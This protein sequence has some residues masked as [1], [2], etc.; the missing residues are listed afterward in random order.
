M[1]LIN[2]HSPYATTSPIRSDASRWKSTRAVVSAVEGVQAQTR[3][4]MRALGRLRIPTLIFVNK[5]DRAGA[6]CE[7]LLRAIA[8][9]LTPA[10]IP[11]GSARGL[12]TRAADAAAY[13]A[14]DA[15]FTSGMVERLADHDEAIL[16]A[17]VDEEERALPYRRLRRALAAQTGRALVHP[18]FFGSAGTC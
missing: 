17:Y 5:I 12:G 1:W 3:V 16:A 2:E 8:Q 13:G 10:I 18:V 15:G 9:K 4:L 14:D 7:R 11:M 6:R